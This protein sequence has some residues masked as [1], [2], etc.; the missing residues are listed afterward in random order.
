MPATKSPSEWRWGG[1]A[2]ALMDGYAEIPAAGS[3]L[4]EN[5]SRSQKQMKISKNNREN[6]EF[7]NILV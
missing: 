6:P 1:E 3:E 5:A 7:L 2:T 4:E